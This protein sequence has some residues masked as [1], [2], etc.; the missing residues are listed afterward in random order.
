V[1]QQLSRE[2]HELW[3]SYVTAIEIILDAS[4]IHELYS[5]DKKL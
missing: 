5:I 3:R 4:R 2:A 1:R